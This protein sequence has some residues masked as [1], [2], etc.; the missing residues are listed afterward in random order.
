LPRQGVTVG[1]SQ[2]AKS[3]SHDRIL[4]IAAARIRCDGVDRIAVAD[5]MRE[6]GLTPR[7]C[8]RHCDSR[9]QLVAEA[10]QRASTKAANA[11]SQEANSADALAV[12]DPDLS[13]Q[14]L[15]GVAGGLKAVHEC[16]STAR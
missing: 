5:L 14:I 11:L 2:A 15:T 12:D 6:G 4:D 16:T 7:A 3:A 1:T 13:R 9:D 10:A 8:Y